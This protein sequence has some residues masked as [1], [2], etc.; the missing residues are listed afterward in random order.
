MKDYTGFREC[1]FIEAIEGMNDGAE[2]KITGN[3]W[4]PMVR[5][6]LFVYNNGEI[7]YTFRLPIIKEPSTEDRGKK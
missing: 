6:I 7:N 3:S 1:T 2:Y 5:L 4:Q